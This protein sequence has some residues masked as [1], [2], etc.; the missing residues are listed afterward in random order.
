M[1]NMRNRSRGPKRIALITLLV[2][3]ITL[4]AVPVRA[5]RASSDEGL[6]V[7]LRQFQEDVLEIKTKVDSIDRTVNKMDKDTSNRLI[8]LERDQDW[9]KSAVFGIIF[10][11]LMVTIAL[12][13][14]FLSHL[15]KRKNGNGE[16]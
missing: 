13:P 12:M 5:Q 1:Q 2:I 10:W 8:S 9:M 14:V 7:L 6:K 3:A 16:K 4:P 15:L 11:L